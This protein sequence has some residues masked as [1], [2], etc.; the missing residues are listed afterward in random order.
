MRDSDFEDRCQHFQSTS[1]QNALPLGRGLMLNAR[2]EQVQLRSSDSRTARFDDA[3]VLSSAARPESKS[4][5]S[6]AASR[7]G[8]GAR[9]A[10]AGGF[11]GGKILSA[12][13]P[14]TSCMPYQ[15]IVASTAN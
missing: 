12:V 13:E 15:A 8:G 9:G 10:P 11:A 4:Q 3:C 2:W 5:A 14:S 1:E 7:R 6:Q